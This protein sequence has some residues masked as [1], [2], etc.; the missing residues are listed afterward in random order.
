MVGNP[1]VLSGAS[2]LVE[3]P[4]APGHDASEDDP[5]AV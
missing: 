1:V 4:A 5:Y 3:D 2:T